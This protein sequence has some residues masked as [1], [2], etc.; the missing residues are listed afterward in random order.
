MAS[1]KA[2]LS[3]SIQMILCVRACV[4]ICVLEKRYCWAE[5]PPTPTPNNAPVKTSRFHSS[6]LTF[7]YG[8][9]LEML[10]C[11]KGGVM[12]EIGQNDG[13]GDRGDQ[14]EYDIAQTQNLPLIG[15]GMWKPRFQH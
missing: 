1:S 12:M 14:W 6:P 5:C 2:A 3:Q 10:G 9:E 11:Q 7:T 13:G 15:Q 4:S 8:S